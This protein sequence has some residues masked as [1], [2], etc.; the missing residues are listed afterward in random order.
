MKIGITEQGDGGIDQSWKNKLKTVDGI[1][2]VTK[3]PHLLKIEDIPPNSVIHC[4]IT[5]WGGTKLEPNV[6]LP[7]VTLNAY[8]ILKDNF[9]GESVVLRV[10]PI[11]TEMP[12]CSIEVANHIKN[13]KDRIRVSF[14]DYYPHVRERMLREKILLKQGFHANIED[15]MNILKKLPSQTEVCGEPDIA[16]TGCISCRD[17]IAMDIRTIPTERKN[18]QRKECCCIAEKTELLS[19]KRQCKHGCL[20]CYWK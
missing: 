14:L 2:I 10:D 12:E 5:G 20:Y 17:L 6:S 15:R 1:I 19:N 18:M 11:I 16:C 7:E 3:A 9:S 4:T 13:N 8:D